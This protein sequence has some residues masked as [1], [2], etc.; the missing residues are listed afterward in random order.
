MIGTRRQIGRMAGRRMARGVA[1]LAACLCGAVLVA[2]ARGQLILDSVPEIENVGIVEHRGA[3]V[4]TDVVLTDHFGRRVTTGDFF[5]GRRPVLLV[6]G[7]YR[8]PLLCSLI[9]AAVQKSL[10]ET[11]WTAGREYRV[12]FVSFDHTNTVAMAR[13]KH[14]AYSAGMEP[15]PTPDGFTFTIADPANVQR[16]ARTVGYHYKYLPETGEFSHPAALVFLTP[17]GVVNTYMEKLEYP[18]RDV[19][20][21]LMEAAEGKTGSIFDRIQHFCFRYD[22]KA[23]RYTA[24]AVRVMQLGA[25]GSAGVL[26]VSIAAFSLSGARRRRAAALRA[27]AAAGA[28][29]GI[30]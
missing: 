18:A 23:G 9:F 14:A 2:P 21:A 11:G 15:E 19:K 28:A 7:Y 30:G 26:G 5:D 29:T 10:N 20:L 22:S 8:C 3:Q 4:P 13:E 1:P 25:M 16:I 12:L 17:S 27:G 6:L 24:D